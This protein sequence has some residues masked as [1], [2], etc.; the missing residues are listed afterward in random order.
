MVKAK[1]AGYDLIVKEEK[2][3]SS[4]HPLHKDKMFAIYKNSYCLQVGNLGNL[5][6]L[7]KK[8]KDV[9]S[10][11]FIN[12]RVGTFSLSYNTRYFYI[13]NKITNAAIGLP[14]EFVS[15][16]S[17]DIGKI[18]YNLMVE[19]GKIKNTSSDKPKSTKTK[20]I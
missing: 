16:L 4:K 12:N 19:S 13:K 11:N 14:N 8:L 20:K 17:K 5:I 15:D 6:E 9:L 1:A 7:H 10:Y 3:S 2:T 18:L